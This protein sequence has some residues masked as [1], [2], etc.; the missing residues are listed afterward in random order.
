[1]K[2]YYNDYNIDYP[3]AKST[4]AQN[5]V[6]MIRAYGVKVDGVG[7]QAHFIVD[8]TPSYSSMVS[9]L[10][11]FTALDVEVGY[12]EL[13]IRMQLPS[14]SSKLAQ[15]S[16]DYER[17]VK[18]CVDVDGCVG[19]TVWDWTDK[20]SWVP[21]VFSGYGAACPWDENLQKKPAYDGILA[22]LGASSSPG[23]PTTTSDSVGS[24]PTGGGQAAH[25][26]QCGGRNWNG[27]TSCVSPYTCHELNPWYSQCL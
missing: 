16:K 2:L 7:L 13:D 22:G 8:S 17:T 24:S 11:A 1:M 15:Q 25:W 18:S 12:T 3:G 9:N 20:Y 26:G 14:S 10:K 23:S 19:V 4:A 21:G 5:L 27:P 6:N